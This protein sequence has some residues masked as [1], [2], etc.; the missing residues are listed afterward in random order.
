MRS[1]FQFLLAVTLFYSVHAH[2]QLTKPQ[3][4]GYVDDIE[5]EAPCGGFNDIQNPRKAFPVDGGQ[6]TLEAYHP[7]GTL[8]VFLHLA[9]P[10][11][12]TASDA[13]TVHRILNTFIPTPSAWTSDPLTFSNITGVKDGVE[14]TIQITYDAGDGLLFQCTDIVFGAQ[15]DGAGKG[16]KSSGMVH[17]WSGAMGAVG[18]MA[19]LV[20]AL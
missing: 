1:L 18:V 7:R 9:P 16:D 19:G 14:A 5:I 12:F 8:N 13:P 4:R 20:A 15:A 6:I 3:S 10:T 11:A 17:R 2:F